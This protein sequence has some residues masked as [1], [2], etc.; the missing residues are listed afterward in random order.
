LI[1]VIQ[2]AGVAM[3]AVF[4]FEPPLPKSALKKKYS[5]PEIYL[6]GGDDQFQSNAPPWSGMRVP[7]TWIYFAVERTSTTRGLLQ[8]LQMHSGSPKRQ[9]IDVTLCAIE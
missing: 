7:V 4:E 2:D 3:H 8:V 5:R 1:E 9:A 6:I